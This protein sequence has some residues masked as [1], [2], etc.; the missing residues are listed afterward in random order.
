MLLNQTKFLKQLIEF[1]T[2]VIT[3]GLK[4]LT[5]NVVDHIEL[6]VK[7]E[8]QVSFIVISIGLIQ[9]NKSQR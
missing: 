2:S 4:L 1:S 8:L 3:C 7:S 6:N 9:T 5:M